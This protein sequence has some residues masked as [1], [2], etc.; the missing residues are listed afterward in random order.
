MRL[1]PGD[2]GTRTGGGRLQDPLLA[3]DGWRV[4]VDCPLFSNT[5]SLGQ[6]T[7]AM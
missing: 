1:V 4:W 6:K 7:R 2:C 5:V 3:S